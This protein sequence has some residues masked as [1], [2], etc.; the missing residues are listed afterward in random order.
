MDIKSFSVGK[1]NGDI[2]TE[3]AVFL[4]LLIRKVVPFFIPAAAVSCYK[5]N[6]IFLIL[7]YLRKI[8]LKRINYSSA[9]L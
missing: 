8:L 6:Y 7:M 3:V 2:L 5:Y 9:I 4:F 1:K